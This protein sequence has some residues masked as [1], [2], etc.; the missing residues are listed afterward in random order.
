VNIA[1]IGKLGEMGGRLDSTNVILPEL[2]PKLRTSVYDHIA[3]SR[4]YLALIAW[5]KKLGNLLKPHIPVVV[6]EKT[7]IR[8]T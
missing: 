8:K 4:Q 7:P 5:R 3:V 1:V 6:S 2:K